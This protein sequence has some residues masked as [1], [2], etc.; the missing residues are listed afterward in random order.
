MKTSYIVIYFLCLARN[1]LYGIF[2][3]SLCP[4][5]A[6]FATLRYCYRLAK[7]RRRPKIT[8]GIKASMM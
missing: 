7:K 2:I 8:T 5:G 6:D 1:N 3:Q 4:A